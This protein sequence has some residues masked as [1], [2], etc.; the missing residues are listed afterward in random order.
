MFQCNTLNRHRYICTIILCVYLVGKT[1]NYPLGITTATWHILKLFMAFKRSSERVTIV[2]RTQYLYVWNVKR[3][4]LN[5]WNIKL[6]WKLEMVVSIITS[7]FLVYIFVDCPEVV[8]CWHLRKTS[9]QLIEACHVLYNV[10]LD[11]KYE[12]KLKD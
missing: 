1:I 8:S 5:F 2:I 10:Q 11:D 4:L 6:V 12:N 7:S 3:Q 9:C